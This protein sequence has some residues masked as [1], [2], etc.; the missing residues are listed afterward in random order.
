MQQK[1]NVK[2]AKGRKI[3]STKW[4]YRHINDQYV[5]LASEQGYRSRAAFKLIEINDKFK[6]IPSTNE[7]AIIDLGC[8]PGSWL[9]VLSKKLEKRKNCQIIGVDLKAISVDDIPNV[10]AICGDFT[11]DETIDKLQLTI[12]GRDVKLVVSDMAANSC[13]NRQTDHMKIT[14]LAHE[15][16]DFIEIT[17]LKGSNA[18]IKVIQGNMSQELNKRA[19]DI[20]SK[21]HWYKPKASYSDSAEIYLVMLNLK[22]CINALE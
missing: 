14:T 4:L 21:V 2:T 6:I 17:C 1:V 9:Q 11:K 5:M 8:A 18:V 19:K 12:D 3:S 13:G 10:A 20:F 7:F 22:H 15:V 16:L